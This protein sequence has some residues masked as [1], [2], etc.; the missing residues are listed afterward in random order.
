MKYFLTLCIFS[1]FMSSHLI[2][3]EQDSIAIRSIHFTYMDWE[4]ETFIL[5]ACDILL[6]PLENGQVGRLTIEQDDLFF[7]RLLHEIKGLHDVKS[8][9]SPDTRIVLKIYF[10]DNSVSIV[11]IGKNN[12]LF[13]NG[14]HMKY[15]K[16]LEKLVR[17]A[18]PLSYYED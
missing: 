13:V 11:C 5:M 3:A 10:I 7:S 14:K 9:N 6:S 17:S 12:V 18:I 2:L 1:A 4:A 16:G 8:T 15:S